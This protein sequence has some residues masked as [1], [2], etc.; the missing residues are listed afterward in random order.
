[1]PGLK[2]G[3]GD[4][5]VGRGGLAG[6]LHH[7]QVLLGQLQSE[8]GLGH[9]EQ[10]LLPGTQDIGRGHLPAQAG[11]LVAQDALARLEQGLAHHQAGAEIAIGIGV[12]QVVEEE[13]LAGEDPLVQLTHKNLGGVVGKVIGLVEVDGGEEPGPGAGQI[14]FRGLYGHPRGRQ[15]RVVLQGQEH[16]LAQGQGRSSRQGRHPP[17]ETK[18]HQDNRAPPHIGPLLITRWGYYNGLPCR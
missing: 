6:L 12:V 1:M 2:T 11:L 14:G 8:I 15:G 3:L 18:P 13:V 17:A 7:R 16:G 4:F 10:Q 5:Q 9:L